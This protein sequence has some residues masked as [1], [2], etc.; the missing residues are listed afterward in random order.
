M[1]SPNLLLGTTQRPSQRAVASS[2]TAHTGKPMRFNLSWPS[3]D[4][5][6]LMPIGFFGKR[7]IFFA[8][9]PRWIKPSGLYKTVWIVRMHNRW[10]EWPGKPNVLVEIDLC[11]NC[12]EAL[13]LGWVLIELVEDNLFFRLW[14]QSPDIFR[15]TTMKIELLS[16]PFD[17]GL[18]GGTCEFEYDYDGPA[19]LT[20]SWSPRPAYVQQSSC[21][22]IPLGTGQ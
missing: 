18:T 19:K 15:F 16:A 3:A 2:T 5:R 6:S 22:I 21:Q 14:G 13:L 10:D 8:F 20:L 12:R 7:K 17:W 9:G 1:I 4:Q 11:F